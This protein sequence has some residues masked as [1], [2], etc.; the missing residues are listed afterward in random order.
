M[1][2]TRTLVEQP[3][4]G[5]DLLVNQWGEVTFTVTHG[6]GTE[7][8]RLWERVVRFQDRSRYTDAARANVALEALPGYADADADVHGNAYTPDTYPAPPL[9]FD[10]AWMCAAADRAEADA[11]AHGFELEGGF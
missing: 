7:A 10:A 2:A 3:E 6:H 4:H 5:R 8:L 9:T 1:T 11:V